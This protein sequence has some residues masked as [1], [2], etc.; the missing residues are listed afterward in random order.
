MYG[1]R[2]TSGFCKRNMEVIKH[3]FSYIN[4]DDPETMGIFWAWL[5]GNPIPSQVAK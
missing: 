3:L 2:P 5:T 1:H 4:E